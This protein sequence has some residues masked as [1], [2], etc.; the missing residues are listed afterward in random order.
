V[1]SHDGRIPHLWARTDN[2]V[3]TVGGQLSRAEIIRINEA[4]ERRP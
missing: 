3:V 2:L 4:L 1:S